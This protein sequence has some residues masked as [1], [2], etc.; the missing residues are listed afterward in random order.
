MKETDRK[1]VRERERED[2]EVYE[3]VNVKNFPFLEVCHTNFKSTVRDV[4]VAVRK[5]L[6]HSNDRIALGKKQRNS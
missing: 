4:E 6:K 3:F 1:R 5:V 2:R